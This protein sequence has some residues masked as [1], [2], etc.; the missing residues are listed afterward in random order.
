MKRGFHFLLK[1]EAELAQTPVI[2]ISESSQLQ[3]KELRRGLQRN[4]ACDGKVV[5]SENI[6][7]Q[8][9]ANV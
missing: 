7:G 6:G 1:F 3:Y 8:N 9:T 5:P 2:L 4:G